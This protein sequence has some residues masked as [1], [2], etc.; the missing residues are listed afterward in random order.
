MRVRI[1]CY[2]STANIWK[3]QSVAT[4]IG[5]SE[6]A[7]IQ[8]AAAL[9]ARGHDVSVLNARGGALRLIGRVTWASYDQPPKAREDVAVLWRRPGLIDRRGPREARKTYLWLHDMLP[10]ADV[11]SRLPVITKV[12]VLSRFHRNHYPNVPDGK[13]M[14]TR[15]GIDAAQF[16][17]AA[18]DRDSR[19][20]VYGSCYT[21]GLRTLL[22]NWRRIR[23]AA[24]GARLNVFYGWHTLERLSPDRY[25]RI[26]PALE[27]LFGQEGVTHLGRVGHPD[28][29]RQYL[30]AGVWAYPCSFPET[31]C[32]SAM[33]AQA[34]GAVPAVIPT[35][36]LSETV[37][38]GFRTMRS[39]TDYR[40]LPFPQRI[41]EE[42]LQGLV[43]LLRS[44][45]RQARIRTEMIPDSRRHFD[46]SAVARAWEQEFAST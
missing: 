41:V 10:E 22:S 38:F 8:M 34:G 9:S 6:E 27:A 12:M 36:A 30:S 15:N 2:P 40:G 28:V 3:P 37:R 32:I 42:W 16:A 35:G 39:Y 14:Q 45:E 19:L 18:P 24:P 7:V 13:I 46:W 17:Q 20:M 23:E 4:G 33:K 11:L 31:S 29:A 21:R 26:R 44:S 43:D 25:Q 5:G 1:Y